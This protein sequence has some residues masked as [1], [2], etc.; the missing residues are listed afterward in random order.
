[1]R[2]AIVIDGPNFFGMTNAVGHNI[3]M[4]SF[5][6]HVKHGKGQK[7]QIVMSYMF[8][9]APRYSATKNPFLIFLE[10]ELGFEII[11]VPYKSYAPNCPVEKMGKSRTDNYISVKMTKHLYYNDFDHLI[12]ISGDSDFE[13]LIRACQEEGKTVEIWATAYILANDIKKIADKVHF[14]DDPK[15]KHLLRQRRQSIAA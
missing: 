10:N 5:V 2:I 6:K 9:D 8:Y 12:L 14:F 1:M 13:P 7:N 15:N 4:Q 11:F 3:D